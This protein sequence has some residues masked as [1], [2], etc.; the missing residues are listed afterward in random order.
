MFKL[1]AHGHEI[2]ITQPYGVETITTDGVFIKQM[3]I[4]N[5]GTCVPQHAH[6]WDHTS[7]LA[8][9]SVFCWKDGKLDQRYEAPAAILVKAGVKHMFQSLEDDT[10][11]YCIHNLHSEDKVAVLAEHDLLEYA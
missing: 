6:V 2:K 10:I 7:L 9:G 8:K 11:L 3:F 1:P 4:R 5:A